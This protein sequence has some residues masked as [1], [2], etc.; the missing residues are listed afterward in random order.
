MF[1][2]VLAKQKEIV[3][4]FW[5]ECLEA[6]D[7]PKKRI[8]LYVR[9]NNNT[10]GTLDILRAWVSEH[11]SEYLAVYEDYSSVDTPVEKYGVH[12][13]NSERFSV[14]A[15]I[16]QRSIEKAIRLQVDYYF[17]IDVDNFLLPHV[18]RDLLKWN[19]GVVSPML[20]YAWGDGEEEFRKYYSNFHNVVDENGYFKS[21]EAYWKILERSVRGL[22]DIEL[23]HCTYLIHKSVLP[24]VNYIDNSGRYEYVIFSETLRHLRVPQYL[25]N[26]KP[27]GAITLVE[28]VDACR[29]YINTKRPA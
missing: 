13:W 17:V 5:L 4:P 2:A 18:L 25:D 6:L 12:E 29:E 26:V 7:Y 1:I 22:L 20:D 15:N 21:N 23:V 16:R 28:N 10:D 9:S 3:L 14:L 19:V 8:V 24:H 11:R 27:H